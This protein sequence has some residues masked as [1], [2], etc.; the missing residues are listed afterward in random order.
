M[1]GVAVREKSIG[2]YIGIIEVKQSTPCT[3]SEVLVN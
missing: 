1:Y 2:Y 3:S